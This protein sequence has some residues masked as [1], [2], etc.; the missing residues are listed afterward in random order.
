MEFNNYTINFNRD[1]NIS[2]LKC[3]NNETGSVYDTKIDENVDIIEQLLVN[4]GDK[5]ITLTI[6]QD[7]HKLKFV[8]TYTHMIKMTYEL[9]LDETTS[10]S[11]D[12]ASLHRKIYSMDKYI[13][14]KTHNEIDTLKKELNDLKTQ[15]DNMFKRK[16]NELNHP[17][18][19]ILNQINRITRAVNNLITRVAAIDGG[20]ATQLF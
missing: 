3:T 10:V 8:L 11:A 16:V 9:F 5:S 6:T 17:L 14:D 7:E 18:N 4:F 19:D 13:K 15:F 20:D 12:Y 1:G 2:Y